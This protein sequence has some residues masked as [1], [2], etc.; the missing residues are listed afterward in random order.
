MAAPAFLQCESHP[1]RPLLDHLTD[2]ADRLRS[3]SGVPTWLPFTGLF[4]DLGKATS[5]FQDY[6]RGMNAP[7]ELKRHS[8]LG[9]LWL[10]EFLRAHGLSSY[11]LSPLDAALA[12][13]FV[14]RHHGRLDDLLDALTVDRNGILRA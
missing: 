9:A 13:L 8:E 2:V 12:F 14:R 6:L 1:G 4:H 10:L 7:P 5:Y 3:C 11:K